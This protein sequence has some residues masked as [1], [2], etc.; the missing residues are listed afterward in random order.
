MTNMSQAPP[1]SADR[2]PIDFVISAVAGLFAALLFGAGSW[3][4][5]RYYLERTYPGYPEL[6]S[7]A[8]V[9]GAVDGFL[10]G[11]GGFIATF[12]FRIFR[13]ERKLRRRSDEALR[14]ELD[15]IANDDN[16]RRSRRER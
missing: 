4:F 2:F 13:Y 1:Y 3:R 6:Y 15:E 8:I 16:A 9:I 5:A 10:F 14:R 7:A 12:A 11:V